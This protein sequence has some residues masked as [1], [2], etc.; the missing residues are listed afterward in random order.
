MTRS[1]ANHAR[2][3]VQLL[4]QE[5]PDFISRSVL[6]NRQVDYRICGLMQERAH[7]IQQHLSVTPAAVT[8][9]LKQRLI[10]TWPSMSHR[11]TS[12]SM[13]KAVTCKHEGKMTSL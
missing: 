6:P 10:D 7:I 8:S 13:E 9:D 1:D 2:E 3:T 4:Q 11:Q 5:T 12:W